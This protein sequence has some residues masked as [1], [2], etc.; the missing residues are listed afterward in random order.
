MPR[1]RPEGRRG[2]AVTAEDGRVVPHDV[3]AE[4]ALLGAL[5]L[6]RDATAAVS[7]MGVTAADFFRREH[8]DVFEAVTKLAAQ[9]EPVDPVTV[10]DE[11]RRAGTLDGVGGPG[12][13]VSLQVRTPSTSSAARYARIVVDHAQM[14]RLHA[15]AGQIADLAV[16]RPEDPAAAV[17]RALALVT[18]TS[19][20]PA[21]GG[22]RGL[23]IEDVAAVIA[24]VDAMAPPTFLARPVWPAG[25]Y[26]VIGAENKAGK[27]WA[28]LDLAVAVAGGASWLGSYPCEAPGPVLLFLGEGD[29]RKMTRRLRAVSR[30]HGA[31]LESLPLR[32]CFR[33][34]K[35]GREGHLA[36]IRAELGARPASLVIV[37]PLYL[38]AT[39]ASSS[40]LVEMG[41][42]LEPLQHICQDA[43]ATLVIVHHWNQTGRGVGRERFSGAGA[44]EWGRVTASA[45]V[46]HRGTGTDGASD[47]VLGWSFVGDE[48]ADSALRLRRQVR[49]KDPGDLTSPL[50]YELEVLP[51]EQTP[52]ETSGMASEKPSVRRTWKALRESAEPATV[53]YL[54]DLLAQGGTPLKPRSIQDA[55][56]RLR[57]LGHAQDQPG[58]GGDQAPR[59]VIREAPTGPHD[60]AQDRAEGAHAGPSADVA[61]DGA[62]GGAH[63]ALFEEAEKCP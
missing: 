20:G 28:A 62:H 45:A 26:G 9:G 23:V 19:A 58:S 43:G 13:L 49:A 47:V 51:E 40:N 35:L 22:D 41:A 53:R 57:D 24:R 11:M 63:A 31:D 36:M 32:L 29:Q 55:L 56:C 1:Q 15:V 6:S 27:T 4:A 52:D 2:R 37:D 33:V 16:S 25:A 34:P 46:E 42:L 12:A 60:A 54:G 61:R 10:A 8:A 48:I 30:W 21:R 3:D 14:R 39:G 59:W 5:L 17:E 44:A 7:S 38:A 18:G 50:I